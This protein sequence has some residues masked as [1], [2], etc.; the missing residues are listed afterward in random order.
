VLA[1]HGITK[2]YGAVT[3]LGGVSVEVH[4]GEILGLAGENGSGKST[5]CQVLAGAIAADDGTLTLDR[6]PCSFGRPRDALD[7]G[8]VLVSQE[9][10]A[11][12]HMSIAENVF[13]HEL[14]MP[15]QRV[16]RRRLAAA[17]RPLLER[18]GVR[19][20]PAALFSSLGSG[21]REL[22]EVAKALASR[23]RLLLLDEVTSRLGRDDVERVFRVVRSLREEEGTA[24][25]FVSHRL[26]ELRELADR[27]VVLRDGLRSAELTR[28]EASDDAL[29]LAMVGR[30]LGDFFHKRA[31]PVRQVAMRTRDLVVAGASTPVDLEVRQGEIVGLAGLVGC[32]RSELL[33]T[34]AGA[35]RPISGSVDVAGRP[36]RS[37]SVRAALDAGVALV[38]EDRHRQ[39]LVLGATVRENVA[40]GSWRA[41][42][43]ARRRQELRSAHRAIERLRIRAAGP[44]APVAS[45]SGGN[46]QK[47]VLARVLASRP[48]VLLLDEPTRGIDVG[49]KA[50]F[51]DL[52]ATLVADGMAVLLASS[53]LLELLGLCDRIVVLHDRGVSGELPRA[54]ATEHAI[55]LLSAGGAV[56]RG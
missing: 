34:V 14:R 47:V 11:V 1:A 40:L 6:A 5:L 35:R 12:P 2:R 43:V 26:R 53:D 42:G 10:T 15:W 21:D 55:A 38:P 20:D 3:A 48:R 49:A 7:R 45:L 39:G 56:A 8:I 28:Q 29:A 19:A 16:R 24:V 31:A 36:L 27:V 25:V 46:Q 4:G 18:V 37:G 13:L 50:E 54:E 41:A 30:D 32:G 23:P 51:Y 33:E 17:A 9:P 52:L 44:Q 22:V